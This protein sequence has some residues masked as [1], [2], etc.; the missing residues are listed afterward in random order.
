M[1]EEPAAALRPTDA[2]RDGASAENDLRGSEEPRVV[3]TSSPQPDGA[4]IRAW[5]R[6]VDG[7]PGSDVA[8]LSAWANVRSQAEFRPLYLLAWCADRLVGGAMVLR[9]RLP[10]VGAVGYVS[11]GP[12]LAPEA[13]R[14]AAVRAVSAALAE[15]G[16]RE[17]AGLFVQPP[18]GANDV[19]HQ[20]RQLGFRP[21]SAGFAPVASL[22]I[23]LTGDLADLRAAMTSGTRRAV[24]GSAKRGVTIRIGDQRDV[25]VLAGL[26]ART[27]A[28]QRFDPLPLSYLHTVYQELAPAHVLVIVAE[29]DGHP[30]AADLLTGCG[31]VLRLRLGGTERTGAARKSGAAAAVLWRALQWGKE[32]GYHTLD[33]GGIR[34]D[35]V[36]TILAGEPDLAARL[37]GPDY[38]KASFGGQP[39]HCTSQ[40]ELISSPVVRIGYDLAR[41]SKPGSRAL[42]AAQRLMRTGANR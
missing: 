3:V 38:F 29:L 33:A 23:D 18:E 24:R 5:D 8:Q 27:A 7:V 6:L 30:V 13:P 25:P 40:V 42:A 36:D 1:E 32:N 16:R 15:L 19:S 17:L 22:R 10:A 2:G 39:F 31:G 14:A 41:R 4:M 9:R 11:G 35:A 28:H 26:L 21:S 12:V 37:T 34:P 20:L